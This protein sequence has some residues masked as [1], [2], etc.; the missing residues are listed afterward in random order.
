MSDTSLTL[1]LWVKVLSLPENDDFMQKNV[2][3]NKNK[4]ALVL[5][6]VFSETKYVCTYV[7]NFK[8]LVHS[9]LF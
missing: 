8:F 2:D 1:L 6:S 5:K 7:P 3:I 9:N 4:R